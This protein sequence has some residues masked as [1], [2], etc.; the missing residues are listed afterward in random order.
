MNSFE[1]V[2]S[3]G[4]KIKSL[5]LNDNFEASGQLVYQFESLKSNA[6]KRIKDEVFVFNS[7]SNE[8]LRYDIKNKKLSKSLTAN[9]VNDITI[10]N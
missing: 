5:T 4:S 1:Y 6:L 3:D 2:L 8:I 10:K 7:N 9:K